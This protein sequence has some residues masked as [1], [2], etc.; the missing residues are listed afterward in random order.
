[1]LIDPYVTWAAYLAAGANRIRHLA[2][3]FLQ[4]LRT[5]CVVPAAQHG[6]AAAQVTVRNSSQR[7]MVN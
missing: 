5:F 6:V 7:D 3:F 2:A 4:V 1:M